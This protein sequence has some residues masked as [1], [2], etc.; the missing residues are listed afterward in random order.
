MNLFYIFF[1]WWSVGQNSKDLNVYYKH[2]KFLGWISDISI[3]LSL[4]PSLALSFSNLLSPLFLY[5]FPSSVIVLDL[6]FIYSLFLSILVSSSLSLSLSIFLGFSFSFRCLC[7]QALIPDS[8]IVSIF[9][10][11]S[12]FLP[13]SFI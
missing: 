6:T 9:L 4:P 5:L 10:S 12:L 3:Y 8:F 13:Y 1:I 11:L 7:P 2:S